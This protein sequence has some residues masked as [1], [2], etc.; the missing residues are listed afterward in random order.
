M[1][2]AEIRA[3]LATCEKSTVQAYDSVN[4]FHDVAAYTATLGGMRVAVGVDATEANL[5]GETAHAK[6]ATMNRAYRAFLEEELAV[7][8]DYQRSRAYVRDAN[9]SHSATVFEEKKNVPQSHLDAAENGYFKASGDFRHVE[10]DEDTDLARLDQVGREYGQLRRFLPRTDKAPTL[11]FRK[12]GRHKALGIYHPHAQNVA[13]DPRHPSSFVHELVHHF[14]H[15]DGEQNVS[16][17]EEFRPL[18]RAAQANLSRSDSAAVKAKLGYYT[19][20][21]EVLS[22]TAEVYYFW[23]MPGTSLNGDAAKYDTDPA[24]QALVP[25][26]EQIIG[27]WDKKLAEKGME[28]PGMTHERLSA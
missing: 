10:V 4:G 13:V 9:A 2:V 5:N 17:G 15:T 7:E 28:I 27:F 6:K 3:R 11:R 21:T 19:T 16:S 18:L 14:D 24:Y 8:Y 26:K 1:D 22:R 25:L 20:P 23:K 12:T